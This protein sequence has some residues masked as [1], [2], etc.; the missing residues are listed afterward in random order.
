M[1]ILRPLMVDSKYLD[2]GGE[3][4]L[5]T[6]DDYRK[7]LLPNSKVSPAATLNTAADGIISGDALLL[8]DRFDRALVWL[9]FPSSGSRGS[10]EP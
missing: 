8:L 2:Q 5:D 4:S 6:I 3:L 1:A 7:T 10:A 9:L